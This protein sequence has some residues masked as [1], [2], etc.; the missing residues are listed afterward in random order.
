MTHDPLCF[1][2]NPE[3]RA[4]M[5]EKGFSEQAM[6]EA[7]GWVCNCVLITDTRDSQTRRC[8]ALVEKMDD[9][10]PAIHDEPQELDSEWVLVRRADVLAELRNLLSVG[11]EK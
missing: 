10:D 5:L 7:F 6:E 11:A 2:A 9:I 4:S 8:I 1:I 3:W